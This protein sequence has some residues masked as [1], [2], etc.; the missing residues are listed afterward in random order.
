MKR[1]R[2]MTLNDADIM[3][4]ANEQLGALLVRAGVRI[5]PKWPVS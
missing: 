4:R 2:L 5:E 3:K 1:K